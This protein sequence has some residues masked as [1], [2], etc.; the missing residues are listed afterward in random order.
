MGDGRSH[1]RR[2]STLDHAPSTR[3]LM[4]HHCGQKIA[5]VGDTMAEFGTRWVLL[6]ASAAH[7]PPAPGA[8][9]RQQSCSCERVTASP[10]CILTEEREASTAARRDT[11]PGRRG[12]NTTRPTPPARRDLLNPTA[13]LETVVGRRGSTGTGHHH[14]GREHGGEA[15][16]RD[17]DDDASAGA[18]ADGKLSVVPRWRPSVGRPPPSCGMTHADTIPWP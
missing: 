15:Q 5:G 12:V 6:Q 7:G 1:Q 8:K 14:G 13:A 9:S 18:P 17:V 11:P 3:R 10:A 2:S 4:A 16:C